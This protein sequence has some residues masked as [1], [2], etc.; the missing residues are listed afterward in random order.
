MKMNA[1]DGF[2]VRPIRQ[3]EA[4]EV[5]AVLQASFGTRAMPAPL[6]EW[7]SSG[8][9]GAGN[10]FMVAEAAGRIVG[11]QPMGVFPFSDGSRTLKGG[12][13]AGLAVHPDYRRRGIFAAL[14]KACENEAWR[15]GASFVATMPNEKSRWGFRKFSYTDLGRRRLLA[16]LLRPAATGGKALPIV[17]HLV[18]AGG[19]LVQAVAKRIPVRD[20]IEVR[21]ISDISDE[22]ETL[23]LEHEQLFPGLRIRRTAEWLR[24]RFLQSPVRRYRLLEARETSG[25]LAGFAVA[26]IDERKGA[27]VCYLMDILISGQRACGPLVAALCDRARREDAHAVATVVSSRRLALALKRAG[28]WLAPGWLPVKRFYSVARFN[29][30]CNPPA[31]WGALTGWYQ[32]LADWDNL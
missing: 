22:V 18:G 19:A 13:L 11:A 2:E 29:P 9:S 14:V 17:G 20:E 27:S 12:V 24:W 16:R 31:S 1:T 21:E 5:G 4:A 15:Q 8:F 28:M 23:A 10:G 30:E 25:R 32:T 6:Y 26:T 3:G 7:W